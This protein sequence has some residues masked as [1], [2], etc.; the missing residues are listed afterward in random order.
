MKPSPSP[1]RNP[2]ALIVAAVCTLVAGR[3]VVAAEPWWEQPSDQVKGVP[4]WLA[5]DLTGKPMKL[6]MQTVDGATAF[7]AATRP[8]KLTTPTKIAAN[9]EVTIHFSIKPPDKGGVS[10]YANIAEEGAPGLPVAVT[11]T[12]GNDMLSISAAGVPAGYRT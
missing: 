5:T 7:F 12:A 8:V 6:E 11:A 3:S 9:T 1:S 4:A 2:F 10:L